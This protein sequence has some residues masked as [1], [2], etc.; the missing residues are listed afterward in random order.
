MPIYIVH[1]VS[2]RIQYKTFK[3]LI[4]INFINVINIY[5]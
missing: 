3:Q 5:V 4:S 1:M 2:K